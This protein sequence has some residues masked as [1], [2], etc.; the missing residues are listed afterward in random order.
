MTKVPNPVARR[1]ELGILLREQR[2]RKGF[3]LAEV[4]AE[5]LCSTAKLSRIEN[6]QRSP[7]PRDMRDLLNLYEINDEADRARFDGLA[8]MGR[9]R[10]LGDLNAHPFITHYVSY[11]LD[12]LTIRDYKGATVPGLLQTEGYARAI[13][14]SFFSA[15][16][17]L[18]MS[19]L[20]NSRLE[21]Q[22]VVFGRE[23]PPTLHSV[24]DEAAIRRLVGGPEVMR[25]Q[26]E[27]LLAMAEHPAVT[28]QVVPFEVGSHPGME[29][30]FTVFEVDSETGTQ[31]VVYS[32]DVIG[33]VPLERAAEQE[34][35]ILIFDK[36]AEV[37]LSAERTADLIREA[38]QKLG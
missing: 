12:A 2:E 35:S 23:D 19:R 1:R 9:S 38:I 11:E 32:E 36:V 21:R 17:P 29:N 26:L 6:G 28:V 13:L 37:A 7:T 5:I 3:T 25:E 8:T 14:E 20:V 31:T 15:A 33:T 30:T 27:H 16:E 34:N 4:A 10:D 18:M 24:M 22:R